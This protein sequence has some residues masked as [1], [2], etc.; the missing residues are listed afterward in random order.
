MKDSTLLS[1]S[2]T[3]IYSC[4]LLTLVGANA[5][6]SYYCGFPVAGHPITGT[7]C[8]KSAITVED[9]EESRYFTSLP[10]F[11]EEKRCTSQ[12]DV[13]GEDFSCI[14]IS[15]QDYCEESRFNGARYCVWYE[16]TSS[17]S[18]LPLPSSTPST[19]AP[20]A[21]RTLSPTTRL[22]STSPTVAPSFS[23]S[24][25]GNSHH[26]TASP[27][28]ME[29]TLTPSTNAPSFYPTTYVPSV[30]PSTLS[31]TRIPSEEPSISVD[32]GENIR[33]CGHSENSQSPF[34]TPLKR[35]SGA[36]TQQACTETFHY[37]RT[38]CVWT[39]QDGCMSGEHYAELVFDPCASRTAD[40]LCSGTTPLSSRYC[41]WYD[42][43]AHVDNVSSSPTLVP[44]TSGAPISPAPSMLPTDEAP[45][46]TPLQDMATM[47]PSRFPS[48]QPSFEPS[49]KPP[50]MTP[51][52]DIAT[53]KPSGLPS[54]KPSMEPPSG[55][56]LPTLTPSIEPSSDL[57]FSNDIDAEDG[58]GDEEE[59][60]ED[61]ESSFVVGKWM[62]IGLS[63]GA[64]IAG[65]FVIKMIFGSSKKN[66]TDAQ[67]VDQYS[68]PR[69]E[70]DNGATNGHDSCDDS[71]ER[72]FLSIMGTTDVV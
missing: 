25:F 48:P 18:M 37:A 17:P 53:T 20:T 21:G 56:P 60:E 42:S 35:C 2:T 51:L 1:L 59:T 13:T 6:G 63:A 16:A 26:P 41:V 3:I 52:Q 49:V 46:M 67:S 62:F 32:L 57:R 72:H 55:A 34:E 39:E 71:V 40:E 31:P 30:S 11:W 50:S 68:E 10:C 33:Y 23:P 43:S 7:A 15:D 69:E 4:L 29:P 12:A 47:N 61:G 9:C 27:I 54:L 14:N 36:G 58:S 45:S 70:D 44:P 24:I 28:T 38:W 8:S 19:N 66:E 65:V 5:D 22:P 64:V